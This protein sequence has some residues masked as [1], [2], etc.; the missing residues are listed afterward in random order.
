MPNVKKTKLKKFPIYTAIGIILLIILAF[1]IYRVMVPA[2]VHA[3]IETPAP[4]TT[5][6]NLD[7]IYK[8]ELPCADCPGISETLILA[9]DGSYILEDVYSQKSSAYQEKS[10]KPFQAMGKWE[11]VNSSVIKLSP[12]DNSA[13]QYFQIGNNSLQM[14]DSNMQKID[15]PFN[16]TLTRQ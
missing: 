3:P 15:S 14:L 16:Q 4:A 8:G 9:R 13:A 11:T 12:S 7:G 6:Q 2:P 1:L 5:A 10:Q